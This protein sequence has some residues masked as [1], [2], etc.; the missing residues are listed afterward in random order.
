MKSLLLASLLLLTT[1]GLPGCRRQAPSE[2][3]AGSK[4]T[5]PQSSPSPKAE[6]TPADLSEQARFIS[7]R[8]E[9]NCGVKLAANVAEAVLATRKAYEAHGF[10]Q[11]SYARAGERYG[12]QPAVIA[13]LQRLEAKCVPATKPAAP[14]SP[15]PV[16]GGATQTPSAAAGADAGQAS[17][18]GSLD[19]GATQAS[20][21]DAGP[22]SPH[23]GSWLGNFT[24]DD[25][26][27]TLRLEVSTTGLA[28][29][30]LDV[31]G[32]GSE[33][34][35]LQGQVDKDLIRLQVSQDDQL[36]L[37]LSGQARSKG[38]IAGTWR[39]RL[40]DRKRQGTWRAVRD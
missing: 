2:A 7:A 29:A 32:P 14:E 10:N 11:I 25:I 30:R 24:S 19:A 33:S 23:A 4:P 8:G 36:L 40:A 38:L 22:P 16:D 28:R 37:E 3:G 5:Q 34:H 27:G 21:V 17:A 20:P 39:G 6:V 26:T 9:A 1:A 31:R 35:E 12:I 15:D 13:Q 18:A